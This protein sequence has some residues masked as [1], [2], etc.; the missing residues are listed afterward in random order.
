L[1]E[2][3]LAAHRLG[4]RIILAPYDNQKDLP[5]IPAEVLAVM[6]V[7][8]VKT[9]DEVLHFALERQLPLPT[10]IVP[11]VPPEFQTEIIQDGELTN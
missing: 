9:M 2:K 8:F 1:K 7:H 11:D 10:Q 4:I 6:T 3:L 5:E